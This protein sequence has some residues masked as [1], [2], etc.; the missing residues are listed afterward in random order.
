MS[1]TTSPNNE[2]ELS[3]QAVPAVATVTGNGIVFDF[4]Y[5]GNTYQLTVCTPDKI[6]QYGFSL[7]EGT[8]TL[9]QLIYAPASASNNN[10][11]GWAIVAGL[12][13]ALTVDNNLTV[14]SISINISKGQ[15]S[16]LQPQ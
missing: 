14:N 15:T 2:K 5:N 3:A 11:E 10:T 16:A 1:E 8:N 12:P 13:K 7:I 4:T 6:G 9:A